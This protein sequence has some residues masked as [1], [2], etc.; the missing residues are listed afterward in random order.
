[1]KLRLRDDSLRLRLGRSEVARIGQGESV[2]SDTHVAGKVLRYGL[3][4]D[5]AAAMVQARLEGTTLAVHVPADQARAWAEGD[6]VGFGA[7]QPEPEGRTLKILVEKDF[8][9]LAPREG[10]DDADAFPH[11]RAGTDTC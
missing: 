10:E 2:W 6:T 5:E 1:M 4:P 3:V 11:P 9:C 8:A 7:R